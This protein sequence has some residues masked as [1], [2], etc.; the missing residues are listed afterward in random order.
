MSLEEQRITSSKKRETQ[1][2]T[3]N[4]NEVLNKELD[5]NEILRII[6]NQEKIESGKENVLD[7]RNEKVESIFNAQNKNFFEKMSEK[8]KKVV[9]QIYE[10]VYKVPVFNRILAKL[11]IAYK[12]FWIDYYEEKNLKSK[13]KIN[14]L[15]FSIEAWKKSKKEIE[16]VI[17]DLKKQNMPGVSSLELKL[18]E[19]DGKIID[20][21]NK[22]DKAQLDFEKTNNRMN[23]Y[24]ESRNKV[25][26]RFI[27][28]YEEKLQPIQKELEKLENLKNK[29][30]LAIAA[31]EI[32]H[33]E[34]LA[35]LDDIEK[36]KNQVE[37]ALRKTGMSEKEIK[38]FGTVK[39]LERILEEGRLKIRKE[40]EELLKRKGEIENKIMLANEKASLYINKKEKFIRIKNRENI[41]EENEENSIST[42]DQKEKG[43]YETY[44]RD[45]SLKTEE[46]SYEIMEKEERF[47]L[48]DIIKNWNNFLKE[49]YNEEAV[50][51]DLKDFLLATDLSEKQKLNFED[52]KNILDKYLRYRKLP[53]EQFEESIDAFYEKIKNM[54]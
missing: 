20:L 38:N 19:I 42:E 34:I 26:D 51:I 30:D 17:E 54:S 36:K 6:A 46:S 35:K 14:D 41:R 32:K 5:V 21:S 49:K 47:E 48:S 13:E 2:E 3:K 27:E 23:S 45:S 10:G 31:T 18:R 28:R 24:K 33:K 12:N 22:R 9:S 39:E 43:I 25:V 16:N 44:D 4:Q 37:E 50:N 11:E 15:K 52:F 8:G 7:E 53:R 40:K 1:K 29:T